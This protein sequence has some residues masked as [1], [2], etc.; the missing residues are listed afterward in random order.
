VHESKTTKN[1]CFYR[2]WHNGS[3]YSDVFYLAPPKQHLREFFSYQNIVT[4]ARQLT[5]SFQS[6]MGKWQS[7]Q[8]DN[9]TMIKITNTG[10]VEHN[11]NYILQH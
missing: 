6:E 10:S 8:Y 3:P 5:Q 1:H 11:F 7:K 9:I 4:S 2:I